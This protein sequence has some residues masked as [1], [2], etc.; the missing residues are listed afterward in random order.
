MG[1]AVYKGPLHTVE[2]AVCARRILVITCQRCSRSHIEWAFTLYQRFPRIR[3][4]ALHAT[5]PGFYC[6]KCREPVS[7]WIST[8]GEGEA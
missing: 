2:D 3:T 1:V 8:R 7:A 4:V 5:V 6:K